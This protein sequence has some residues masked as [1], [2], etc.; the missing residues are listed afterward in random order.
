MILK[1][2]F[3]HL[4]LTICINLQFHHLDLKENKLNCY[5]RYLLLV[6]NYLLVDL[7]I[8]FQL[9]QLVIIHFHQDFWL[10]HSLTEQHFWQ[11]QPNLASIQFLYSISIKE[12]LM[13]LLQQVWLLRIQYPKIYL[14]FLDLQA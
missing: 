13:Q 2:L 7:L 8:E 4:V 9:A 6:T 12:N 3:L 1:I 5:K 14:L 11:V 10:I